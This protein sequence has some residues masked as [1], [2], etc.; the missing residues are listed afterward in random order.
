MSSVSAKEVQALRQSTGAGILD[1]RRALEETDS[2]PVRAAQ[3][4]RENGLVHAAKRAERD[5]AAGAVTLSVRPDAS[6]GALMSLECETDFV[7]KSAQFTELAQRLADA[8]LEAD[9]AG[10]SAL[11]DEVEQLRLVL[12]ENIAIGRHERFVAPDTVIGSYLHH[13][14]G[15][16]VNGV[17]VSLRSGSPELAHE[18][19]VHVAFSR[20][21]FLRRE[22][23]PE[24]VVAE[25]RA[26][27]ERAARNEGK[28][29][30]AI[31]K[32]VEGRLTGFFKERCLLEQPYVKD[33]KR[34]I[35]ALLGDAEITAFA[36]VVV[37][38]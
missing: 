8:L 31:A 20:P 22:D 16:G 24:P 33:E 29:E 25:E 21:E 9:E 28:P 11:G 17:L 4:L 35:A 3:W 5:R 23:V 32:I 6:G 2:D 18:I 13:Q 36:Q 19:A 27:V 37:G 14:N 38:G 34:T 26:T 10:V 12:K 15:R 30:A 7:A 1:A